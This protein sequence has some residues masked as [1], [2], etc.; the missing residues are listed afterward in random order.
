MKTSSST[1]FTPFK[2]LTNENDSSVL[3]DSLKGSKTVGFPR[4]KGLSA[5]PESTKGAGLSTG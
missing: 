5:G 1:P 3:Q 4:K 2:I